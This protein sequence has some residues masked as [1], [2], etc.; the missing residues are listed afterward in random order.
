MGRPT[1]V[2]AGD[3]GNWHGADLIS[4]GWVADSAAT[5]PILLLARVELLLYRQ[6]AAVHREVRKLPSGSNAA[7]SKARNECFVS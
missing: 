1:R 4:G 5:S 6:P 7:G 2:V 3:A